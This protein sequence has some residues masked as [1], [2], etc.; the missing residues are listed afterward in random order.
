MPSTRATLKRRTEDNDGNVQIA[1]TSL[2][3]GKRQKK[4]H[5]AFRAGLAK[6][7]YE[8]NPSITANASTSPPSKV[9]PPPPSS[10][11]R[12]RKRLPSGYAA[13]ST[14]AHLPELAD[15][16]VP[17][18]IA[19]FI[20]TNPGIA[21]ATEGHAY[22]HPSNLF[23][24]L[25]H[26]SGCTERRLAPA[27]DGDL[28]RLAALGNTNLVA[29]PTRDAAQLSKKEMAES[30]P[31]LEA[32]IAAVK[33]EAV[34]VVGKGIWEAIFRWRRGR[35]PR[36]EEFK[37]GWQADEE[38]LGRSKEWSGARVF[39]AT[40]TSGLS[41]NLKPPEKL[42]IWKPFGEWVAQRQRERKE[43]G[44]ANPIFERKTRFP[45]GYVKAELLDAE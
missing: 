1:V 8:E 4:D 21:T 26:W 35:D 14:Y 42:A 32:R 27:E 39:V 23:W 45:V 33:P 25:V 15:V 24:K 34:C 30:T 17:G 13:P 6:Y 31:G 40:S 43:A 5:T 19:A 41:A 2:E 36:K 38:N 18:L 37:Y 3:N 12:K 9:P 7:Q 20:G 11:P 22:A 44:I 10:S 29:R 16:L 28:P